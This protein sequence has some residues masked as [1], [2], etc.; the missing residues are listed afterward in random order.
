MTFSI[1]ARKEDGKT[2]VASHVSP[3]LAVAK[4]RTQVR[5]GWQ[6][7]I[8]DEYGK[9]F[10]PNRFEELLRFDRKPVLSC[11]AASAS[12]ANRSAFNRS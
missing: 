11:C 2:V 10:Q 12:R 7:Q 8:T 5:A 1:H 4:A 6:V 3:M 9:I